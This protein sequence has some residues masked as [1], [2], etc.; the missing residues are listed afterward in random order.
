[1]AR[2]VVPLAGAMLGVLGTVGAVIF[3]G[4]SYLLATGAVIVFALVLLFL[5][6]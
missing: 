4:Q 2:G 5:P 1:M 3:F 6:R